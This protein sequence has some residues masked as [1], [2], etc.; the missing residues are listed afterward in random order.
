M[1]GYKASNFQLR[2]YLEVAFRNCYPYRYSYFPLHLLKVKFA[3]ISKTKKQ[4]LRVVILR[5]V[6][7]STLCFQV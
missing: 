6:V 4:V 7:N 1:N 3:K 2:F 5:R